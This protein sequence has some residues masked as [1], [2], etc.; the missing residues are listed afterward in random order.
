[1][2]EEKTQKKRKNSYYQTCSSSGDS[3]PNFITPE[4]RPSARDYSP[5]KKPYQDQSMWNN[6]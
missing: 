1:M 6:I 4:K 3:R 2:F 5:G